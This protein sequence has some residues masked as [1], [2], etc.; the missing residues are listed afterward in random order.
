MH[1][2]NYT[3]ILNTNIKDAPLIFL[4]NWYCAF[5]S[6]NKTEY[7]CDCAQGHPAHMERNIKKFGGTLS[8]LVTYI[9]TFHGSIS[10]PQT[11]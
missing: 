8:A 11:Q 6:W 2:I 5:G 4:Y 7:F 1:N 10:L 3:Q 9:H